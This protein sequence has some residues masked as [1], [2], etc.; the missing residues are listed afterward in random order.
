M[1]HAWTPREKRKCEQ[2]LILKLYSCWPSNELAQCKKWGY[3]KITRDSPKLLNVA[4]WQLLNQLG[5]DILLHSPLYW[6]DAGQDLTAPIFG[7]HQSLCGKGQ[8]VCWQRIYFL[9][10]LLTQ[11]SKDCLNNYLTLVNS[12][13]TLAE[14]RCHAHKMQIKIEPLCLDTELATIRR[15][16]QRRRRRRRRR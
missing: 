7:I 9:I 5:S 6:V 13:S 4:A 11:A 12:L 16:Q 15:R 14:R 1:L 10:D 8:K 3:P 2:C